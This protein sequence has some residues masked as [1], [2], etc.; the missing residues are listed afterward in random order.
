MRPMPRIAFALP[1]AAALAALPLLAGSP[2]M[3]QQSSLPSFSDL[4]PAQRAALHAEIRA[5]LL[6]NPEI[7]VEAIEVLENRRAVQARSA[8]GELIAANA[9]ALYNDGF[10]HVMGNPD[11]D[12]TVVEFLDY[13]CGYC[14]RAHPEIKEMLSRDPNIRLIVKEFPILGPAS[15]EAGKLA[16][17]AL[18]IDP[19]LYAE[20]SDRLMNY[21]GNLTGRVA[22]RIAGE[23][24]YNIQK[25]KLRAAGEVIDD[26]LADN[27]R[28]A[29]ALN[30]TGTPSFV[31][32]TEIIRG[33][34]PVDDM[35][36]AVEAQRA[37]AN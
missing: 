16:L 35:L 30:L 24:G 5:Y 29:Q 12:V 14:K 18:D 28:V 21:R 19:S 27:Y 9:E 11:G 7:I 22:Y 37:A 34:L 32:G 13:R 6:E 26:R 36:A 2:A 23:V 33:Y 31:V 25:L 10:S 4:D 1:V 8:D 17:A 20:L 3:A 15:V